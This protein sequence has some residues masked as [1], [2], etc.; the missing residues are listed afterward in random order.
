MVILQALSGP[1]G[2]QCETDGY[3][4]HVQRNS[5]CQKACVCVCVYAHRYAWVQ[6]FLYNNHVQCG[7]SNVT[8]FYRLTNFNVTKWLIDG[9]IFSFFAPRGMSIPS[10][11]LRQLRVWTKKQKTWYLCTHKH[12]VM[13][14][15]WTELWGE[16]R[17]ER[18]LEIWRKRKSSLYELFKQETHFPS[19]LKQT[20]FCSGTGTSSFP[21]LHSA[22]PLFSE[23]YH[24]VHHVACYMTVG[25]FKSASWLEH[26]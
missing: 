16:N 23:C 5:V 11:P 9:D 25:S 22:V 7:E 17:R 6:W 8:F 20:R 19:L 10:S 12:T 13:T 1:R 2:P 26:Y 4:T 15:K 24:G 21:V 18:R 14:E 3:D